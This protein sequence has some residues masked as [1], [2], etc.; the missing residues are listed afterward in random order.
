M[1]PS[2]VQSTAL[3]SVFDVASNVEALT[4]PGAAALRRLYAFTAGTARCRV[5]PQLGEKYGMEADNEQLVVSITNRATLEQAWCAATIV[6]A[7]NLKERFPRAAVRGNWGE[8]FWLP[9][10]RWVAGPSGAKTPHI[11]LVAVIIC[12]CGR[13]CQHALRRAMAALSCPSHPTKHLRPSR[14][15]TG[16]AIP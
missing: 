15:T 1:R 4:G 12:R 6:L 9:A 8:V 11:G 7:G 14:A 10:L 16:C 13:R 3:Q 5:G 2:A